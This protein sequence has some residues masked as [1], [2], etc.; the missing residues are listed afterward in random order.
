MY[1]TLIAPALALL[2]CA[3]T[4]SHT[5]HLRP[6]HHLLHETVNEAGEALTYTLVAGSDGVPSITRQ[7]E[8]RY[9]VAT[10]G[11]RVRSI[12]LEQAEASALV[13]WRGVIVDRVEGGSPAARA[14]ILSGDVLLALA[15]TSLSTPEQLK[16]M[17]EAFIEPGA[18]VSVSLLKV[19][20]DGGYPAEPA[21]VS[22]TLG[23]KEVGVTRSET[24]PLDT[25]V[26]VFK[27]TG[28][29]V[30]TLSPELSNE[31]YGDTEP[32]TLIAGSLVGSPAYH[33]GL[34]SGDRVLACE[35]RA[36]ESQ[37]DISRAVLAR[38]G[39]IDVPASW[40]S[41]QS[42]RALPEAAGEIE[43]EV[44]GPLGPH[45]A[46]FGID[47]DMGDDF[48]VR[49]PIIYSYR[50]GVDR[51]S[52]SFLDFIFQFGANYESRYRLSDT[53]A[54][55]EDSLLSIF[56]FGMFEFETTRRSDRYR[57]LWFFEFEDEH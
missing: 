43:L 23:S 27:L 32:V 40:F 50:S 57:F 26:G 52:W 45:V 6:S 19:G 4:S 46:A 39:D 17:L 38:A 56:P 24:L 53:R 18:E 2:A 8:S 55:Q 5:V 37:R 7:H 42:R 44:E 10:I 33:A 35:G 25:D 1:R 22:V 11:L 34:R 30:G 54:P 20:T 47:E 28:L 16:E 13:P 51:S 12:N 14:G 3:C 15:G 48:R 41:Q 36:I 49:V 31:L 29:Q 21:Q 9:Q